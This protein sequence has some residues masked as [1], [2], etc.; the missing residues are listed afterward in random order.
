MSKQI[1]LS[2]GKFAVVDDDD[3]GWL[4][5]W[6]WHYT[7][8]YARRTAY[9]GG[10]RKNR[11]TIQ[12]F[13]HRLIVNVPEELETDHIDHDGLNNRRANLRICTNTEN[14]RNQRKRP[15]LSSHYKGVSWNKGMK[16]WQAHIGIDHKNIYLGC[17][18]SPEEAA[19]AYDRA[20]IKY[21]GEF[22]YTNLEKST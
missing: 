4:S 15:G 20:A 10:G 14:K 12:I 5:R 16:Q 1:P 19:R 17:R 8:G 2:K 9:L 22:A 7:C 18:P 3:F 13:M 11:Q 21:F 6:K